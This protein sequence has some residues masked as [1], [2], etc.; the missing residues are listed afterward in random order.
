MLDRTIL[1]SA[2]LSVIRVSVSGGLANF[3][4]MTSGAQNVNTGNSITWQ[5]FVSAARDKNSASRFRGL[6]VGSGFSDYE[7]LGIIRYVENRANC[8]CVLALS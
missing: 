2:G 6:F 5:N 1:T 3:S 8:P 7:R 4:G